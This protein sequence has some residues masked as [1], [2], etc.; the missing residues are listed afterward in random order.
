MIS[1]VHA[2]IYAEDADAARAF[3]R[4]V[5]GFASVDV[6]DGWL[7]FRLPPA[8]L[9]IHPNA[10]GSPPSG[11]HQLWLMCSDLE[12]EMVELAAKGVRFASPVENQG[13]GRVTSI[14]V[15]GA[16]CRDDR[17]VRSAARDGVR[18]RRPA[19]SPCGPPA[20]VRRRR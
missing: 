10:S 11:D 9:G 6:H 3:F 4:D 7:I 13:F 1:S 5:L 15:L 17:P 14:E 20:A 18:P 8:E 19:L 12:A 16:G 2:I